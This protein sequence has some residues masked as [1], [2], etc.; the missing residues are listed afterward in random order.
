MSVS[1]HF[2]KCENAHH[3]QLH[4]CASGGCTVFDAICHEEVLFCLSKLSPH[5]NS[6][7]QTCRAYDNYLCIHIDSH[8]H[9]NTNHQHHCKLH[10]MRLLLVKGRSFILTSNITPCTVH[11]QLFSRTAQSTGSKAELPRI[12]KHCSS[13]C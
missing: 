7:L 12:L 5:S 9:T 8:S 10:C 6:L 3:Y 4:Q 13:T 2:H 1:H 11:M